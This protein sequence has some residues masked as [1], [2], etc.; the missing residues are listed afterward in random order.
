MRKIIQKI[1]AFALISMLL[2]TTTFAV[3]AATLKFD[4]TS[5]STTVGGSVTPK[6][7]VSSGDVQ[8]A[9]TDIYV[10][11]DP[12]F[13]E[14]QTVT[15]GTHFPIVTNN[16]S[17][18]KVYVSAVVDNSSQYKVG[19]GTVATVTFKALKEGS[20]TLTYYCD[21][22]KSDTSKIVKNDINA[23][24]VIECNANG[25]HAI[26][27]S[28][29]GSTVSATPTPTGTTYTTTTTG[30]QDSTTKGGTVY[31]T[32]QTVQQLPQSGIYE[33]VLMFA[34]PGMVLLTLGTAMR[35]FSRA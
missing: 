18:G 29:T 16:F 19:E 28:Q 34:L 27:I 2:Q 24:N 15:P 12:A 32:T 22:S 23:T 30:A 26:T 3:S 11:Y 10:I 33:N 35:L 20:T 6:I 31:T 9:G 7:N 14:P 17:G 4:P 8:I 13:L 1:T 25:T 21:T 5:S